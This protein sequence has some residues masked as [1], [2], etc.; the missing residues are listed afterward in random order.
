MTMQK[1][2]EKLPPRRW[3][4]A[5]AG[6]FA[7]ASLFFV[8]ACGKKDSPVGGVA[9]RPSAAS[10][11]ASPSASG[12]GYVVALAGS[13]S[14]GGTIPAA[15]SADADDT[16]LQAMEADPSGSAAP[17]ASG[18][19]IGI[20]S[21]QAQVY[22]GPSSKEARIG[23][24]RRGAHAASDGNL[25]PGP[26]CSD[27]WYKLSPYGY[28]C[29]RNATTELTN[30]KVRLGVVPPKVEDILP[31]KYARNVH[32][33]T[34]MYR[35][36]PNRAE[37]V[38]YEPYL[39]R[40]GD[41]EPEPKSESTAKEDAAP[42]KK[43]RD[44]D[45]EERAAIAAMDGAAAAPT[46]DASATAKKSTGKKKKKKK[47]KK[48]GKQEDTSAT[49]ANAEP[50]ASAD[51]TALP[52][53]PS[54]TATAT[55]TAAPVAAIDPVAPSPSPVASALA[56]AIVDPFAADAGTLEPDAGPPKPWWQRKLAQGE[57]PEVKLSDLT[58][59]ADKILVRRM[60][61][62][63]YVAVDRTFS[64]NN[65]LFHHTTLG[66]LAPADRM[67]IVK[68][69]D[70]SGLEIDEAHA[71]NAV[72]FVLAKTPT[73][74]TF[75]EKGAIKPV[76]QKKRYDRMYLTGKT[77]T[78]GGSAFHET[79][80]GTWLRDRDITWT[81]PGKPPADLA[82][83]EKWIDVNLTTGTLVAFEGARQVFATLVSTGKKSSD[84]KRDHRT[85][86]GTWRV[87]EKHIAATMDGDGAAA[88]D[89]PYSIE[90]VPYIQYFFESYALHGAFWHDNFGRQQ[91]HGCVNLA[92]LDAKRLFFWADPPLPEGWHGVQSTAE[93]PGSRVVVHD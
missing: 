38:G 53:L 12:S 16:L 6:G 39:R 65:R 32:N 25:V 29:G 27:G 18:P 84:K 77:R 88:G 28:V 42:K 43:K 9:A 64:A 67:S 50:T 40:E 33:G 91:S 22:A 8:P 47:K 82:P 44:R 10:F 4:L 81:E 75:D 85:P 1:P 60:V 70:L 74:Y 80:D 63:F 2:S 93:H 51:S 48:K 92:P 89:L 55:D 35:H 17:A 49:T 72:G 5:A 26:G 52:A 66:L 3:L 78:H 69:P 31:Y 76:G 11:A 61:Q 41:P 23:Y 54:P 7:I 19:Q 90:D 37:M 62:G 36:I 45:S 57:K 56:G 59:D 87:R 14:K 24:L 86:T 46:A 79:V 13:G 21:Q 20:I 83:N 15:A 68:P 58:E 73:E 71:Q 34:P 30:A